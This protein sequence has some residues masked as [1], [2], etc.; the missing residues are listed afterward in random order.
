MKEIIDNILRKEDEARKLLETARFESQTIIKQAEE[1]ARL[2]LE[3]TLR[4]TQ[5][6][7]RTTE[8]QIVKKYQELKEKE[9]QGTI[10]E[11]TKC[12]ANWS[13]DIPALAHKYFLSVIN[14]PEYNA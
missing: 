13:Q 8:E 12:Y 11:M 9:L 1:Q 4:E 6:Q 7:I 5:Q 2:L 10:E 3:E 14:I